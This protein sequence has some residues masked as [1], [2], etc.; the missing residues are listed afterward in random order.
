MKYPHI[1]ILNRDANLFKNGDRKVQHRILCHLYVRTSEVLTYGYQLVSAINV[2]YIG[3]KRVERFLFMRAQYQSV[4]EIV[5]GRDILKFSMK[6]CELRWKT[7]V[8]LFVFTWHIRLRPTLV[9]KRWIWSRTEL[10]HSVNL[11]LMIPGARIFSQTCEIR[12]P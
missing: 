3:A 10:D 2:Y 6:L 4:M 1:N 12:M 8:L 11:V 7:K 5:I 9:G